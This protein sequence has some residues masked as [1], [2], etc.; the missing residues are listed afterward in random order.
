[1]KKE[2]RGK[3]GREVQPVMMR[4]PLFSLLC[5]VLFTLFGSF[6]FEAGTAHAA[7]PTDV[8]YTAAGGYKGDGLPG[9]PGVLWEN[10]WLYPD[11]NGCVL[12]GEW[13][14]H[15][16]RRVDP[17]TKVISGF[18]G[19][20]ESGPP[21]SGGPALEG[22]FYYPGGVV[23][24]GSGNTYV[25]DTYHQLIRKID[26][27]G[28]ITTLAGTGQVRGLI[29]GEGGDPAD[30][31]G[32]GGPALNATFFFPYTLAF[33]PT[34]NTLYV[35]ED[36]NYA[37]H[38]DQMSPTWGLGN[39]IRAI[40]LTTGIITTYAGT[41]V[42]TGSIDGPGLNPQDDLGDGGPAVSCT[43]S[44]ALGMAV[45]PDGCLYIADVMNHRV[46]RI[47][48]NGV[49]TTLAGNG[50]ATCSIDGP[51]G[52][53]LDDLNDGGPATQATFNGP[54]A[55]AFNP[56]GE[57]LISDNGNHRIR[58]VDPSGDI[59]TIA[60][61]GQCNSDSGFSGDGGPA[62]SADLRYPWGVAVDAAGNIYVC[63]VG[64][65]RI[66]MVT[67]SG[68]IDTI[69]GSPGYVGDG[70]PATEATL[71]DPFHLGFSPTGKM[72]IPEL[73]RHTVRRVDETGIITT[74][75]GNGIAS[76]DIDGQGGDPSDDIADGVDAT[77]TTLRYPYDAEMDASGNVYIV[78]A[79]SCRIRRVDPSGIITTFAGS[80]QL[81]PTG[82]FDGEGGDPR[83]DLGDNGDAGACT[84]YLPGDLSIAPNGDFYV[85]DA[86]N[87]RIRKIDAGTHIITTVAGT[88]K[89]CGSIDG[90]GGNPL[91]DY[92]DGC[93]AT[94]TCLGNPWGCT[95]NADGNL[96]YIS[97]MQSPRIRRVDL[98]TGVITTIGG[99]G[100]ET[101]SYDGETG[102]DPRD[103]L[104]DSG[105]AT[106]VSLNEPDGIAVDP[107]GNVYVADF[108]N[109]RVRKIRTDGIMETLAGAGSPAPFWNGFYGDGQPGPDSMCY[110]VDGTAYNP[111]TG[112][113]CF[114]DSGNGR[115]R[116]FEAPQ[117]QANMRKGTDPATGLPQVAPIVTWPW[118][119]PDLITDPPALSFYQ[120]DPDGL[121]FLKKA[122]GGQ[123]A[124]IYY[125][126]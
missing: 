14:G 124:E 51:G 119:D 77:T 19:N 99:T 76:W 17:S 38:V 62:T 2:K 108:G 33:N 63:D 104:I 56:A 95:V 30:D 10:R 48:A 117:Q 75:A 61:R 49:I 111:A 67:T 42:F 120:T 13:L 69:A 26:L 50:H 110:N 74:I 6:V 94:A 28:V 55:T 47:D 37:D 65:E 34:N 8:L 24:D 85:A 60:G 81:I 88:G 58:K 80:E 39:R 113:V 3:P 122:P 100:F 59:S 29:D 1:V 72:L 27:T 92:C 45:G 23:V 97:E 109:N 125:S 98:T 41:G 21:G 107:D 106:S 64:N 86:F 15:R 18:A 105:P 31:L 71:E 112:E 4:K 40:D 57:L 96:L 102:G 126:K 103:D 68:I 11:G 84:F 89:A 7:D 22:S 115:V 79:G 73:Q 116:C 87:A 5:I 66:R 54:A 90:Q 9:T 20:G 78:E 118:T 52:V 114:T 82:T 70:Q 93:P 16:V 12:F 101:G 53:P 25:A 35:G 46:R 123:H 121:I 36:G 83:D 91:D 44:R 43:F 32:D